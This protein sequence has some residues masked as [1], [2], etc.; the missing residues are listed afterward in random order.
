MSSLDTFFLSKTV[1]SFHCPVDQINLVSKL[2]HA[3]HVPTLHRVLE[4]KVQ[5]RT[6]LDLRGAICGRWRCTLFGRDLGSGRL[7]CLLQTHDKVRHHPLLLERRREPFL[8]LRCG[9]WLHRCHFSAAGISLELGHCSFVLHSLLVKRLVERFSVLPVTIQNSI[10]QIGRM[11]LPRLNMV[12]RFSKG[13]HHVF[14]YL[15][16]TCAL[17]Y[18]C[19]AFVCLGF[20]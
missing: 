13:H 3:A 1:C 14:G 18:D 4:L 11:R 5:H 2:P 6:L 19:S 15:A 16:G 10:R 17:L 9:A 7:A 8:Q 20:R 12:L